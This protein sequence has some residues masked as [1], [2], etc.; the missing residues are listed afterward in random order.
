MK[1][2]MNCTESESEPFCK[3]RQAQEQQ[4]LLLREMRHRIKNLFALATGI[5]GLSARYAD[6]PA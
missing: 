5:V 2:L 3:R 6:T 1:Y 4:H